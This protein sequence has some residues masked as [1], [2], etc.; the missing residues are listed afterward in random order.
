MIKTVLV[1]GGLSSD[2]EA[3]IADRIAHGSADIPAGTTKKNNAVLLEGIPDGKTRLIA[4]A[5]TSIVRIAIG[6]LCCGSNLIMRVNLNRLIHQQPDRLFLSLAV[7]L[8]N[9]A[10]LEQIKLFLTS[11][12]YA[13]VLTL[14]DE[15]HV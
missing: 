9:V 6:C 8:T 7:N 11:P 10:H 15:I 4:D 5:H 14:T 1:V 2:R 3:A 13:K 12:E